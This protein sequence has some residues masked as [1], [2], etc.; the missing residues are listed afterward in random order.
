MLKNE[1]NI[2]PKISIKLEEAKNLSKEIK[3]ELGT[4]EGLVIREISP[5]S[6]VKVKRYLAK[7]NSYIAELN[8]SLDSLDRKKIV[9]KLNG[10][11]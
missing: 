7:D 11:L 9:S 1:E 4:E 3:K 5:N 10:C 8:K 2:P 6:P